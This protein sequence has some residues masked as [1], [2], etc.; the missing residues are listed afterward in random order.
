MVMAVAMA[1]VISILLLPSPA[2]PVVSAAMVATLLWFDHRLMESVRRLPIRVGPEAMLGQRAVA[3]EPLSP[4]GM[5]RCG[6][7]L[8]RAAEVHGHPVRPGDVVRVV[9]VRGLL[10]EVES[11]ERGAVL[12]MGLPRAGGERTPY[13]KADSISITRKPAA[14]ARAADCW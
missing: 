11:G 1:V 14:V 7:E 3:L 9:R 5:V 2:G 4:S 12:Y 8:W 13:T 10:L 6:G